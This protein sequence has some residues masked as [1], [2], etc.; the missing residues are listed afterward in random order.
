M[1]GLTFRRSGFTPTEACLS[2][3]HRPIHRRTAFCGG[4]SNG[5]IDTAFNSGGTGF[6]QIKSGTIRAITVQSDQKVL[7]GGDFDKVNGIVRS[8]LARLNADS[9]LDGSFALNLGSVG[10]RFTRIDDI[11]Y[12]AM[13]SDGKVIVSGKFDY[14][15]GSLTRSNI[16]RLNADGSITV[17]NLLVTVNDLFGPVS[18]GRNKPIARADGVILI[19]TSSIFTE[20]SFLL[21]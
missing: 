4:A 14:L 21:T 5:S 7:I 17:F 1:R 10:N 2:V 16:V 13:Q 9:S 18:L 8:K 20:R 11:Y 6:Q 15:I 3:I 12:A 19:G